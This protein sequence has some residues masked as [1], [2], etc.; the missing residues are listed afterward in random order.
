MWEGS[1]PVC[2]SP[3]V[4]EWDGS[5]LCVAVGGSSRP[6]CSHRV[7]KCQGVKFMCC[8]WVDMIMIRRN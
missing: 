3:R 2:T 6:D 4:C 7:G 1:D 5:G 8:E